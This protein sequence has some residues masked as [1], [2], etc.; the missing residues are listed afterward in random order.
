MVNCFP[1][2]FVPSPAQQG[3]YVALIILKLSVDQGGIKLRAYLA[4][5]SQVPSLILAFFLTSPPP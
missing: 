1:H 5:A 4:F 3:L 2:D